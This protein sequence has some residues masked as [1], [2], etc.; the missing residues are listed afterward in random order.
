[1]RRLLALIVL[2]VLIVVGISADLA[3]LGT[4]PVEG[5]AGYRSEWQASGDVPAFLK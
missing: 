3:R 2:V 1:M 5:A 4:L